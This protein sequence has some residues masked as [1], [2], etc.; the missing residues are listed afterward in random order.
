M[1]WLR[2]D[3]SHM[4]AYKQLRKTYDIALWA[5]ERRTP[6]AAGNRLRRYLM[7]FFR[8]AAVAAV[9]LL[10]AYFYKGHLLRQA[11][12]AG[13][14]VYAP[15][16]QHVELLLA[17]GTQV[18]LNSGSRLVF[19]GRFDGT[20][21]QVEL[22]GEGYFKVS[23]CAE[24]PFIVHTERC[25]VKV[26]GTEFNVL[27]YR[28]DTVWETALL[29][30]A[31][32]IL[33]RKADAPAMKLE[34]GTVARLERDVLVKDRLY[35][36]DCFR[37]REG[38][39]CFNNI[40]LRDMIA[41]LKLYYDVDFIV[42]RPEILDVHYTGKFRTNDGIEHVMRVLSLSNLFRYAKDEKTNVITIY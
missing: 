41:K 8:A 28:G 31:V 21:R 17:D 36:T 39:I 6:S 12:G 34:P 14:S 18:W 2:Q 37:W 30:G 23:P 32:E 20:V 5:Q 24:R 16:G 1:D 4:L 35:A 15:A 25:D 13:Q 7:P 38:L 29:K 26:L 27:A 11:D 10:A 22:D 3:E 40:S 19:P 33:P 9:V 42:R